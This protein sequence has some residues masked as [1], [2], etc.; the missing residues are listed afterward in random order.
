MESRKPFFN[1]FFDYPQ[2]RSRRLNPVPEKSPQPAATL[3]NGI[4]ALGFLLVLASLAGLAATAVSHS[5]AD[6]GDASVREEPAPGEGSGLHPERIRGKFGYADDSGRMIIPARFDGA[7]AFS[8]GLAVVLD[9]GRFGYID[10]RGRY[11]IPAVYRHARAF[12][13]GRASVRFGGDWLV[14][15]RGGR[16]VDAA[17][18]AE[19]IEP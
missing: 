1:R 3:L 14:I 17:L 6:G 4:L 12:R 9:S 13:E 5:C 2:A 8:E 18:T 15:D 7:D 19:R 11:A 10:P 16:T